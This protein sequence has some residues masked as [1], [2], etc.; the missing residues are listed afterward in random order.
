[1]SPNTCRQPKEPAAS[2]SSA[3]RASLADRRE[4]WRRLWAALLAPPQPSQGK[5]KA[6]GGEPAAQEEAA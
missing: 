2:Q 3:D 1:M 4:C 5:E 6:A